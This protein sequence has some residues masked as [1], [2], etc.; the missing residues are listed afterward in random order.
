M[1]CTFRFVFWQDLVWILFQKLSKMF[2]PA[3]GR[4]LTTRFTLKMSKL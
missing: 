4:N 3:K 2:L 1:K